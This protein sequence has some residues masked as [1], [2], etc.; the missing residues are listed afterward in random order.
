[1]RYRPVPDR[2]RYRPSPDHVSS[3]PGPPRR[4]HV[5]AMVTVGCAECPSSAIPRPNSAC[6]RRRHRRF[7]NVYSCVMPWRF[8]VA[9]SAA[10]LRRG[11][12]PH[13]I[14]KAL[15]TKVTTY[16]IFRM[17]EFLTQ[18]KL[19]N[20]MGDVYSRGVLIWVGFQHS[21]ILLSELMMD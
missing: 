4:P 1:M 19:L 3:Y 16:A 2:V 18:Y 17:G 6:N 5:S 9:R 10:R 20:I 8:M 13:T 15:L 11:V 14:R 7:T 21:K 12:G